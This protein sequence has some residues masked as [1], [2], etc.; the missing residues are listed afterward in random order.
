MSDAFEIVYADDAV[1]DI[2][3]MR[4][5]DQRS[6]LD[7]IEVHLSSQPTFTS[8]SRIKAMVQPFWSQY[9]LRI[10]DFRVYYDVDADSVRVN[11]LRVLH[12]TTKQTLET[13]P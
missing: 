7:G 4:K 8:K 11:V 9:R 5:V 6:V 13:P 12:K 1:A 2:K 10:A 3:R